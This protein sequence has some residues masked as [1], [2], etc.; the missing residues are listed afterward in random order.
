[1][2]GVVVVLVVALSGC[3]L[4][5]VRPFPQDWTP[6]QPPECTDGSGAK[7][8]VAADN[9]AGAASFGVAAA[10]AV[11]VL[12]LVGIAACNQDFDAAKEACAAGA[13]AIAVGGL[14]AVAYF[15]SARVGNRRVV[16]CSEAWS[17]FLQARQLEERRDCANACADDDL[18]CVDRCLVE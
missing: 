5:F 10:G 8:A 6:D 7:V 15:Y 4:M 11:L 12:P 2:R 18:D 1:M 17:L 16:A 9:V 14:S 3:S 13:V